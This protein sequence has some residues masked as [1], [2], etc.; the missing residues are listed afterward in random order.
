MAIEQGE[1]GL[2][3]KSFIKCEAIRS[4]STERLQSQCGMVSPETMHTIED[5]LR[6]L[7]NL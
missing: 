7:M 3:A 2:R 4:I 6:I 1:R 5:R